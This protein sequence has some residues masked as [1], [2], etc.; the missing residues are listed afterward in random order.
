MCSV[1]ATNFPADDLNLTTDITTPHLVLPSGWLASPSFY[2]IFAESVSFHHV[3]LGPPNP[4]WNGTDAFRQFTFVDDS[5]FIESQIGNR[6][7]LNVACWE[8]C[9]KR[10]AGEDAINQD[11]LGLEGKWNTSAILL[12]F[13]FNTVRNTVSIPKPKY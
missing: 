9:L 6:P 3:S 7:E 5:M 2:Q 8:H 10:R 13:E 12:G 11:K 4:N 1:L